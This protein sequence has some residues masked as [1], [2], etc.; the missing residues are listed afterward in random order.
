MGLF[1]RLC[2]GSVACLT[3]V[4]STR[5]CVARTTARVGA[6][7]RLEVSIHS[8]S[9]C[10]LESPLEARVSGGTPP[11]TFSW[12]HQGVPVTD[13]QV[14]ARAFNNYTV[15]VR[16]KL[17][18]VAR[19]TIHYA[20]LVIRW[21]PQTP[22]TG[23]MLE[24]L[25]EGGVRPYSY[26][27][28]TGATS[29]SAIYGLA[30]GHYHVLVSDA[31]G[32]QAALDADVKLN[33]R[34]RK[35]RVQM[36][37]TNSSCEGSVGFVRLV[38]FDG[39]EPYRYAWGGY[40]ITEPTI[41]AAV[42]S[43]TYTV[44]DAVGCTAPG[45]VHVHLEPR[46]KLTLRT[47]PVL[48]NGTWN[49]GTVTLNTTN[50]AVP[51]M[52]AWSTGLRGATVVLTNASYGHYSVTVTDRM[53]CSYSLSAF[54]DEEKDRCPAITNCKRYNLLNTVYL[55]CLQRISEPMV[56]DPTQWNVCGA[57]ALLLVAEWMSVPATMKDPESSDGGATYTALLV[58]EAIFSCNARHLAAINSNQTHAPCEM[59]WHALVPFLSHNMTVMDLFHVYDLDNGRYN[60]YAFA[61]YKA[62]V[63]ELVFGLKRDGADVLTVGPYG[64]DNEPIFAPSL[65]RPTRAN[66]VTVAVIK[67]MRFPSDCLDMAIYPW[68]VTYDVVVSTAFVRDAIYTTG[69][70]WVLPGDSAGILLIGRVGVQMYERERVGET[71]YGNVLATLERSSPQWPPTYPPRVLSK[72]VPGH[73]PFA[74]A[75]VVVSDDDG[76]RTINGNHSRL[77][78][79]FAELGPLVVL[80][81]EYSEAG[82]GVFMVRSGRAGLVPAFDK[83]FSRDFGVLMLDLN[84]S[85]RMFMQRQVRL[86]A[87][88]R[89]VGYRFFALQGTVIAAHLSQVEVSTEAFG[90]IYSTIRHNETEERSLAFVRALNYTGFAAA[91]W[92]IDGSNVPYLIDFNARLERHQCLVSTYQSQPEMMWRDPC[93]VFQQVVA[94]TF[95]MPPPEE[96]PLMAPAGMRYVDPIRVVRS[97]KKMYL[98][99]LLSGSV[100]WNFQR[101]DLPLAETIRRRLDAHS[102]EIAAKEAEQ[103]REE[104]RRVEENTVVVGYT[105]L[106]AACKRGDL[107]MVQF[108]L[109]NGARLADDFDGTTCLHLAAESGNLDLVRL[110][111]E[112]KVPI[113]GVSTRNHRQPAHVPN[114]SVTA[115]DV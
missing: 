72:L 38:P 6:R 115:R 11:Y 113:N 12:F 46:P 22:C 35:L 49:S 67:N 32:C 111:V 99:L 66:R 112:K 8:K 50:I 57:R 78:E 41:N 68:T 52:V 87:G 42:G 28:S 74:P 56:I 37:S 69:A 65:C 91:W 3:D 31:D 1:D 103:R 33:N 71:R 17:G 15:L 29:A 45:V 75:E 77:N 40:P 104:Q 90:L 20:P 48:A 95:T 92:W 54:V 36:E 98:D 24:V 27:W 4:R 23:G 39:V 114:S 107:A 85:G 70:R 82:K 100:A 101:D 44:T 61:Q 58:G 55:R 7:R 94:N 81:D 93:H 30:D 21:A 86:K 26:L 102:T 79:A 63:L 80:K 47:T 18:C 105:A 43:Y 110:L 51:I 109:E 97:N 62:E 96:L 76:F 13:A 5:R 108:L 25:A 59:S 83:L 88:M 34:P 89:P 16:D 9:K 14:V 64:F 106:H 60:E 10:A 73:E 84:L 19:H 53:A 2:V